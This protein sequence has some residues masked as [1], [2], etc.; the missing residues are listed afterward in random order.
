MS[1]GFFRTKK[2]L[3]LESKSIS[4]ECDKGCRKIAVKV[5]DIFMKNRKR[6]LNFFHIF[7]D[8]LNFLFFFGSFFHT[9]LLIGSLLTFSTC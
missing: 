3:S 5:I 4:H 1:G 7:L 9:P 2:D 8:R 6:L